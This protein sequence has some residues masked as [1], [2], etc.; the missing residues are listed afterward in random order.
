MWGPISES[1]S[2]KSNIVSKTTCSIFCFRLV[3]EQ[4]SNKEAHSRGLWTI[5]LRILNG[6][7][8]TIT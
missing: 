3:L 6:C 5:T 8:G 2:S 7:V 4:I 1:D